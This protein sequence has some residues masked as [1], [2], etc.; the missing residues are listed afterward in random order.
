MEA[1]CAR[2]KTDQT[3]LEETVMDCELLLSWMTHVGEGAWATFRNA[4]EEL[5]G[6]DADL[7]RISRTLRITL[8]DLGFAD[9]FIDGTQRWRILPPVLGGLA[10]ERF[11]AAVIGGRS[12]VLLESLKIAAEKHGCHIHWETST[13]CP[14]LI[15]VKGSSMEELAAIADEMGVSFE[16]NLSA[17]VAQTLQPV[18]D[19]L[20]HALADPAPLNWKV[21]SFNFRTCT[22]EDGLRPHS[23]C[24]YMPTHGHPK[25][26]IHVKRGK[27]FKVS[28]RESLYAAAMLSGIQ[29]VVY[30]PASKRLSVPLFAP[31][32]EL[33]SRAACL[34]SGRLAKIAD[35][36]ITYD[37]ISYDLAALLMVAAGQP[38]PG[39]QI[40]AWKGK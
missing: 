13:D 12:P 38:H 9:F 10:A 1:V 24:E 39:V 5:A 22:W 3:R 23:A 30:E 19:T 31:L 6:S 25:Y 35:G 28:K 14:A 7:S 36:R 33:Y 18:P 11:V 21:R 15:R 2:R 8:S 27:L 17:V 29:M 34:C 32:P 26:F 20:D 40:P 16:T 4:V 37:E